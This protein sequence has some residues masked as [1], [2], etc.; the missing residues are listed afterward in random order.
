MRKSGNIGKGDSDGF[1]GRRAEIGCNDCWI[2]KPKV[3]RQAE[4]RLRE[5]NDIKYLCNPCYEENLLRV[6]GKADPV[7]CGYVFGYL[8]IEFV[9]RRV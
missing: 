6:K 4:I 3:E 9:K 5:V 1:T 8:N 7:N 2:K